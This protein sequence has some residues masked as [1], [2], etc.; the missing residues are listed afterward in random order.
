MVYFRSCFSRKRLASAYAH[1]SR[2]R[3]T[4]PTDTFFK[5]VPVRLRES[6]LYQ[7]TVLKIQ[8]LLKNVCETQSL[9]L[10]YL[11]T[12]SEDG[13]IFWTNWC[14]LFTSY[15]CFFIFAHRL[16]QGI[17]FIVIND[18]QKKT[19]LS[20]VSS[21]CFFLFWSNGGTNCSYLSY[22]KAVNWH[23]WRMGKRTFQKKR[24]EKRIY[25]QQSSCTVPRFLS[26]VLN[27]HL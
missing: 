6:W 16:W 11:R 21:V 8:K 14:A 27:N 22:Y 12:L 5:S 24:R 26:S 7:E 25:I 20:F 18:L 4:L 10:T 17:V 15:V 13:N 9:L 19:F 1:N 3:T 23:R 2:K